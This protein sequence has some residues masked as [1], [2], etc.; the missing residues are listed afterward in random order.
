MR[1]PTELKLRRIKE[2]EAEVE[3]EI[4]DKAE[5]E[6][7][8]EFKFKVEEILFDLITYRPNN[9]I[10]YFPNSATAPRFI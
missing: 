3:A 8:D 7:K 9:L 4:K 5:D 6:V 10:S 1:F 2:V